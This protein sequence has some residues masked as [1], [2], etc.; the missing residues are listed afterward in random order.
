MKKAL[1]TSLIIVLLSTCAAF[2]AKY[3]VNTSGVVKNNGKVVSPTVNTTN[4]YNV[5]NSSNYVSSNTVNST[6][7]GTIELVMDY[8]GSMSNWITQAKQAMSQ[9]IAQIPSTT[10]VG[11]R[12]FGHDNFGSNPNNNATLAT[13]KK[14]VKQNGKYKVTTQTNTTIGSTS[15]YCAATAQVAPIMSANSNNILNGMNSISVGGA[16]PL[17]YALDRAV[18]QDFAG[19]DRSYAKKIVLI[20]DGGEN[21]GGDPCAFAKNLISQR[22]DVHIDVVLVSGWFSKLSCLADTTGG[23]LYKVNNLSNFSTVLTESM[24][25]APT[26]VPVQTQQ[27][28]YYGN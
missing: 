19:L 18:N 13:V 28:E 20:T 1:I 9:I 25:T 23:K 3:K 11:F 27:Y 8:S 24:T 22:N 4:P 16:T 17:V 21:C 26:Q 10:K 7:V 14:I 15:G 12:V 5:Y 6:Q 2:A